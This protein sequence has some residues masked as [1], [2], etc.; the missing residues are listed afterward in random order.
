[1]QLALKQL[2]DLDATRTDQNHEV[3]LTIPPGKSLLLEN[4]SWAGF[5]QLL[6]QLGNSRAARVA[7]SQGIL[8]IMAP[9]PRHEFY[10]ETVSI[11]VQEFA[12]ILNIDYE[13]FG[14]TTWKREDLLSGL[15]PDNCFYIQSE[16]AI[17]G[18]IDL[19]LVQDP[20]PD[21]ALEI[22]ITSKSLNRMPIYARLGV[23]EV[24]RYNEGELEIYHLQ[25]QTY[26]A[27]ET[28]LALPTFPVQDIIAF[29]DANH[30]NGKLALRR[31]FRE[32]VRA[33]SL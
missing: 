11:L 21:L 26:V 19:D 20:P 6:T 4:I 31:A 15:E 18:K 17:R 22:D 12:D 32:W 1:M 8:E 23:P 10:K 2:T 24:W 7:Y 33:R 27:A 13:I 5:E 14:S 9:L 28:S 3:M 25:G 29:I 16:P 30:P